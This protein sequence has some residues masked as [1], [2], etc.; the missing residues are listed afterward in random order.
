MSRKVFE[1]REDIEFRFTLGLTSLARRYLG[2]ASSKITLLGL[3]EPV[4]RSVPLTPRT[5]EEEKRSAA[6]SDQLAML[7]RLALSAV[8]S[9]GAVGGLLVA[10]F[11][12]RTVGWRLVGLTAGLYG[13]LYL[14]QRLTYTNQARQRR[15][16]RQY[17]EHATRKLRQIV[18]LTST[19]CSH[20]VQQELSSTF[21]RL[22]HL[23]DESISD[24]RGEVARLD[25]EI[26]EVDAVADSAKTLRNKASFIAS[27][28][29]TFADNFLT[30]VS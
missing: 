27:Q 18:D 15:F 8:S 21:A 23:V 12:L 22:C 9:Q 16:K 10:G 7:S 14:Y 19:S 13:S 2:A 20:Q 1:S 11:L 28:L 30:D 17:V 6:D 3:A 5:P 4:P 26:A 24:M 25:A 29:V